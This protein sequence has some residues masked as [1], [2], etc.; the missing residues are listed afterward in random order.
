M[1]ILVSED[2]STLRTILVTVLES[3]GH[4]VVVTVNGIDALDVMRSPGAPSMAILDWTM[5]G[6]SGVEV[7]RRIRLLKE[8]EPPYLILLTVRREKE[9]IVAGLDA[10]ANDYMTKPYDYNELR[11]RL[12]VGRR[13]IEMQSAL[14]DK[15]K[16]LQKA[17][18][19]VKTLRGIVPI[20]A[21]CKKIRDDKGYWQ[22]VERYV[23]DHSEAQFTHGTCPDCLKRLY[24]EYSSRV[25]EK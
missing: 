9:N 3:F 19:E 13:M 8:P 14:G 5:P 20:C 25:K 6:M 11:A 15:V 18:D 7:C 12:D 21:S 17:L 22:Q 4:E 1:R 23:A 2:D 16:E 24:P 10:G